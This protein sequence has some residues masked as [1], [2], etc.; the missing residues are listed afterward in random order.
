MASI[1]TV[2]G[3]FTLA[4]AALALGGCE[5]VPS[6]PAT[7][8]DGT[9]WAV[10]D[11][12]GVNVSDR[13]DFYVSFSGSR[14]EGRFGCR[15]VSG[16]YTLRVAANDAYQPIFQGSEGRFSGQPCLGTLPEEI[17]PELMANA[18]F[19]IARPGE[20]RMNFLQPPTGIAFRQL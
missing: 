19:S 2:V 15:T 17:G 13:N 7:F 12:N 18:T 9:R 1:K 14:F 8:L 20:G 5:T 11:V 10:I 6:A 3:S 4:C 16:T